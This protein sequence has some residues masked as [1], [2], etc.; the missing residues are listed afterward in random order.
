MHGIC[1]GFRMGEVLERKY[2]YAVCPFYVL[3]PMYKDI[4][5]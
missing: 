1:K 5:V 3:D 4:D 2:K